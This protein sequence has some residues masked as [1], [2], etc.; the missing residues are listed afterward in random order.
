MCGLAEDGGGIV[1]GGLGG[2]EGGDE[3]GPGRLGE[4]L[5]GVQGQD[6]VQG[7]GVPADQA[8]GG[9]V[10]AE[11]SEGGGSDPVV[12]GLQVDEGLAGGGDLLVVVAQWCCGVRR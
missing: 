9:L 10:R 3:C 2:G 12:G 6:L 7:A 5:L 4:D 1:A 11:L 8:D